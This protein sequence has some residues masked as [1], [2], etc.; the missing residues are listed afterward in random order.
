MQLS[1]D[2]VRAIDGAARVLRRIVRDRH[3]Y[4]GNVRVR[5]DGRVEIILNGDGRTSELMRCDLEPGSDDPSP[6]E[7]LRRL[8]GR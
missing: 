7:A 3:H 6:G 4:D 2:E 8:V 1:D 5:T